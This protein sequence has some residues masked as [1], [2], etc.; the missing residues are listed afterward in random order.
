MIMKN[1]NLKR[2]LSI[3][4]LFIVFILSTAIIVGSVIVGKETLAGLLV[5]AAL[6]IAFAV[7]DKI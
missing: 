3:I 1:K 2:S 7:S 4:G 6:L 5:G